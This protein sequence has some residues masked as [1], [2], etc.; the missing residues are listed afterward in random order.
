[1]QTA[2]PAQGWGPARGCFVCGS[3]DHWA[4]GCPL[5]VPKGKGKGAGPG[6]AYHPGGKGWGQGGAQAPTHHPVGGGQGIMVDPETGS[7]MGGADPRR[8]GYALGW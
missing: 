2:Q 1:M 5:R 6:P 4:A 7:F 3:T 8:D